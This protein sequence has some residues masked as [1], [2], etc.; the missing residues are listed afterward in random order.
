MQVMEEM[1]LTTASYLVLGLVELSGPV[2]PY[3]LKAIASESVVNFW[4]LPHTQIYTQCDRLTESGYL[5][6]QREESG[7]RRRQ[8]TITRL[9]RDALDAWREEGEYKPI[10]IRDLAMLKTFFGAD[11]KQ[12]A[13]EQVKIHS[14]TLAKYENYRAV[15]ANAIESEQPSDRKLG[16]LR[17]LDAGIGH[18]REF[19]RYW[20]QFLGE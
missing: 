5:E 12:L 10:E 2:T 14:E 1:R 18:E 9:G 11:P 6:E 7:R 4:S 8:F 16:P 3:E 17:A 15:L 19:V 13:A 20:E